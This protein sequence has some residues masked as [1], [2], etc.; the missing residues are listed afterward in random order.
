MIATIAVCATW[1]CHISRTRSCRSTI[2][3]TGND[4][5]NQGS[6]AAAETTETSRGSC[7]IVIASSGT[8]AANAPSPTLSTAL[9]HR[10]RR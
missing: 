1:D 4:V 6:D 7:V 8:A 10:S 9:A 5:T 2:A 3:P